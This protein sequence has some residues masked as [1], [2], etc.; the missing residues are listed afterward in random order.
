[1]NEP[2]YTIFQLLDFTP[3][4]LKLE[5]AERRHRADVALGILTATPQIRAVRM[6]DAEA[7]SCTPTDVI[8]IETS[9]LFAYYRAWERVRDTELFTVPYVLQRQTLLTLEQGH[10]MHEALGA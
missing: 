2:I 5:R 9:D 6:F 10:R 3:A 8:L 7:F 1:M 4:W